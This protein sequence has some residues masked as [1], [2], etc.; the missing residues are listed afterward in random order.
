MK[1]KVQELSRLDY[2]DTHV[3]ND[4]DC[5]DNE[6]DTLLNNKVEIINENNES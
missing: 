5:D 4:N 6:S 1:V 2:D 3:K